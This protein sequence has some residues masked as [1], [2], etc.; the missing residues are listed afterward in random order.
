MAAQARST[1]T[2]SGEDSKV[3][4]RVLT[5]RGALS[6]AVLPAGF[7]SGRTLPQDTTVCT[8]TLQTVYGS[9]RNTSV[10]VPKLTIPEDVEVVSAAAH[11]VLGSSLSAQPAG[12]M[13]SHHRHTLHLALGWES[14]SRA[15]SLVCCRVRQTCP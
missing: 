14:N 12:N 15:W 7:I 1:G 8:Y 3:G 2:A 11:P 9:A 5:R 10:R 13:P 6:C 4:T